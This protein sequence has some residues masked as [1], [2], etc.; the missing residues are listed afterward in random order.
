MNNSIIIKRPIITEKSLKDASLG[1]Y[2]FE[3]LNSINKRRAKKEIE[4][5]FGVHV[6][7]IRSSITKGKTKNAGRKRTKIKKPDIKKIMVKLKTGEKIDLFEV[8][9]TK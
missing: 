4:N 2:T 8:G 9:Q 5:M 3:V 7:G 6:T 1:I